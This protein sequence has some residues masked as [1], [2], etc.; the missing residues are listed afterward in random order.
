MYC[1]V[2]Q[3]RTILHCDC[4]A[5]F[6]SCEE[7]D[8]KELKNV[9]MA[10]GGNEKTRHGIILAKNEIA[11]GY[12]I[13]TAE[14][15]FQ[16]RKKCP[17]L[18]IVPPR[19]KRYSEFSERVN[20]IYREYTE[21]VEPFGIDESWLDVTDVRELFGDGVKI[22]DEL[23]ERVRREV[24]LT[25]SVGVSFTKSFAKLGSDYKKPDATTVIMP[26]DVEKIVYPQSVENLL[27]VGRKMGE[28][29][30]KRG[31]LTIGDLARCDEGYIE[32]SFGKNGLTIL[33]YA[34]GEDRS[35][36]KS[37]YEKDE[38][39]SVGNS[40]TFP[41]DLVGEEEIRGAVM[42]IA[43]VVATRLRAHG[44]KCATVSVIIRD[45]NFKSISRQTGLTQPTDH[46]SD[47]ASAA[48]GLFER[49]Y[50]FSRPVSMLGISAMSLCDGAWQISFFA[51]EDTKKKKIDGAMDFLREKYGAGAVKFAGESDFDTEIA[52]ENDENL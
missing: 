14:T 41:R 1:E 18:V 50:G 46:A 20:K 32:R 47:F 34:K 2:G 15:I 13:K 45:E 16:A 6:A 39:K 30:K 4:N 3:M 29:L 28:E 42:R 10:V 24:G 44:K 52:G 17:N 38:V 36:V 11:K 43:D 8:N 9:P 31:I 12:G 25:I 26:E 51:S 19:H 49:G 23:R 33:S 48:M 37:I 7:A 21:F 27:F 35:R 40:Y 22:A 5:F